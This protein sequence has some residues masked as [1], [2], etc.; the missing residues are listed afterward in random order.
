MSLALVSLAVSVSFAD[1][2]PPMPKE[3]LADP[4]EVVRKAAEATAKRFLDADIV[5]LDDRIHTAYQADGSDATWDDEWIKIL[6]EKGRRANATI[7]MDVSLR[8]G[9]VAVECVE[10]VGTNGVVR[11]VDFNRTLKMA[12]DNSSTAS[13]IYDPLDKTISCAVPGLCVGEIRHVRYCRRTLKPR[14][15]GLWADR[16]PME[17]TAPIVYGKF[18]IDQ[19]AAL[20]VRHAVIRHPFGRTAARLKDRAL[21]GGRT[22][23]AWEVRDVPQAFA[24]PSMPPMSTEV[25]SL[26]LSTAEDWLTVSRWYWKMCEPHLAATSTELTNKVTELTRSAVTSAERLRALFRFVSQEIR[27]MGITTETVAPGYE[28]HD[29]EL[30]FANRYG[31]CRDK[32]AL[33][34][35][36]LRL[37]GFDAR[38]VLIRVGAKMD[39][40]IP[41][42]YFNHAIAAVKEG[43][44]WTLM[45]PTDEAAR[46][47]LPSYLS[48]C[49]Y[50]VASPS[51]EPLR[52]SPVTPVD[53][54]MLTVDSRGTLEP[55]GSI[56]LTTR[57]SFGG[58]ND[59]AFRH[60]FVRQTDDRRRRTV[61]ALLRRV[62]PG[63]ELMSCE[64]SPSDLS[65]TD[66]PLALR[67]VAR[68]PSAL[69]R[70]KTKDRLA[71][72]QMT[73][74][75]SIVG[76]FLESNT[77]LEKRRFPLEF[78]STAGTD[79]TL[80]LKLD[81][82]IGRPL[83]LPPE[84]LVGEG[85]GHEYV[86]RVMATNGTLTA[87]RQQL[88]RSIRF[89]PQEY[90]TLRDNLKIIESQMR[91]DPT[92]AVRPDANANFRTIL[93]RSEIAF[94]S[95]TSWVMTNTVE[96]EILTYQGKKSSAELKFAYS[97]VTR[98][99]EL[100]SAT[101]SNRSGKVLSVTPKEKHLLDCG[102][103]SSAPRYPASRTLVVNLP[104]V[105]IGSVIRYK[106]AY[107]V[108]NAPVA[109]T[110]FHHFDGT[111]PIDRM[112]VKMTI[113][114]GM[115]LRWRST[116]FDKG[117]PGRLQLQD[118]VPGARRFAWS[119]SRPERLPDEPSQP[120][121]SLWRTTLFLTTAEW[122]PYARGLLDSLA[123]AR[124]AGS[125]AAH[126]VARKVTAGCHTPQE[127]IVA[128]RTFLAHNIRTS[129]P[130]LF[131]LPFDQAFFPPD[132]S[133]ADSY[134][135][136]TD[137]RN[138]AFAML[139]AVGFDCSF[140]L[141]T[142]DSHS[143][144]KMTRLY[145]EGLPRPSYFNALVL[146]A[147]A[148]GRTFYL[149]GENEYTPPD[150]STREGDTFFDP[151]TLEFGEVRL[152]ERSDHAWWAP[153][154]WFA[155]DSSSVPGTSAWSPRDVNFCRMTIR[156]D[157]GV[158]FDVTNSMYGAQVGGFRKRFSEM[159]PEKRSRFF[160]SLLGDIA[161]SATATRELT[162]DT[163]GYPAVT[164]FAAFVPEYAVAR[165][166]ELTVRVPDFD[167]GF[168]SVGGPMR[169]SPI[170]TG[171]STETVDIYELVFP[172]GYTTIERLPAGYVLKNPQ[173]GSPWVT[174]KVNRRLVEGRLSVTLE[175]H[176]HRRTQTVLGADYFS[177]FRDWNRRM[178]APSGRTITIRRKNRR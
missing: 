6:T 21:D 127:R 64:I 60:L 130:G 41:S 131:E 83:T 50:L 129:G 136:S 175:R 126:Q 165:D 13:N 110:T 150:C 65:D 144:K 152:D 123:A 67:T 155:D 133:L 28:P 7:S 173:D 171:G 31:V 164:S 1:A 120:P 88:L 58:I 77:A 153:W 87:R 42:P 4:A 172:K 149:A 39:P 135:S 94:S 86:Y 25:Q 161:E 76:G 140:V 103:A 99:V 79:E 23:L 59:T 37:A 139:E 158:D 157:G 104:G 118:R 61:E 154:T 15:K 170:S 142:D 43:D 121:S 96:K 62:V 11:K 49:S 177:F 78:S 34:V 163:T 117:V 81:E 146:R 138:L 176:V 174:F 26:R 74:V 82:T 10:I 89:E 69:L 19:P 128:I 114:D 80:T 47:L 98:S 52:V 119:V 40:E 84:V 95:P 20:P 12:T 111:Q 30:T 168:L 5:V 56:L 45:D 105:E 70:G 44:A 178:A 51:G 159:L 113:P 92:F 143:M 75:L 38:P 145:Q 169:R 27:Y 85:T 72:P 141:V 100:V 162:T 106:V 156:E 148:E 54:N 151:E 124:A 97:P 101:V 109:F 9:D 122:G 57:F 36:M 112:T 102:W 115:P 55:D 35:A 167:S 91:D 66:S 73:R 166:G 63:T 14:M 53:K 24:E 2:P 134:A 3:F 8:Y 147:R 90:A 93:S 16:V 17:L 33:L 32:A 68:F 18:T 160:Q 71:L 116:G 125:D 46:E 22:L 107:S 29:V 137:R 108:T 132:R 48:D